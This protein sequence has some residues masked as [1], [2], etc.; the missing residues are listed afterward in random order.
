MPLTGSAVSA[1]RRKV[2]YT[3]MFHPTFLPPSGRALRLTPEVV[4]LGERLRF[5]LWCSPSG[6]VLYT[7]RPEN[8]VTANG[9][10]ISPL[11]ADKAG[12]R[13]LAVH[14]WR[15]RDVFD[16]AMLRDGRPLKWLM[17]CASW[18][19]GLDPLYALPRG[20]YRLGAEPLAVG[21][22]RCK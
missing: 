16:N 8:Y 10:T 5:V 12:R 18:Y 15:T 7:A 6:V 4:F 3:T 2:A 13:I 17:R 1:T 19:R 11:F 20:R 21:A 14:Q 22:K 9:R